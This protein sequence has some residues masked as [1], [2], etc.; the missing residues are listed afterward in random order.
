MFISLTGSIYV[1]FF[2]QVLLQNKVILGRIRNAETFLE[3]SRK[4]PSSTCNPTEA[5]KMHFFI[6]VFLVSFFVEAVILLF[7]CQIAIFLLFEI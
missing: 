4:I 2:I 1:F 7:Y 5:F 6:K 3:L